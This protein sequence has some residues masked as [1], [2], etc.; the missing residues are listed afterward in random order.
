MAILKGGSSKPLKHPTRELKA[1]SEI[2]RHHSY[3][4]GFYH[5]PNAIENLITSGYWPGI[6]FS[7]HFGKFF[8]S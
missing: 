1:V 8:F 6:N 2:Q 4:M 7:L 3:V 5:L